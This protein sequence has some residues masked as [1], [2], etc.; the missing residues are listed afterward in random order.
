MTFM[1]TAAGGGIL[2]GLMASAGNDQRVLDAWT[3]STSGYTVDTDNPI[4]FSLNV[5]PGYSTNDLNLWSYSD[6]AWSAYTPTDLTYDGT[7]ASFTATGLS[8]YAAT[9][10]PEAGTLAL[11][12][13][14]AFGLL[15][16]AGWKRRS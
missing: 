15:A 3:F 6:G 11:L 7:Y 14:G 16:Y 10:V 12:V 1:A 13:I 5:G 2:D 8:G 4:Y 9:A